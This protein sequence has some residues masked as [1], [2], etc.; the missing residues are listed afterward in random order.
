MA[1]ERR[2]EETCEQILGDLGVAPPGPKRTRRWL[3]EY[4]QFMNDGQSRVSQRVEEES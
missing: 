1:W 3:R 2:F 4:P